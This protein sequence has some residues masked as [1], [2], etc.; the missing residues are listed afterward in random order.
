MEYGSDTRIGSHVRLILMDCFETLVQLTD[1]GYVARTG[2]ERFIQHFS[3]KRQIPIVVISDA[4]EAAIV[5]A[6]RQAG[7][8]T[9]ISGIYDA[10]ASEHLAEGRV[11]KRL[12]VPLSDMKSTAAATVF[13][14]DSPLDADAARYHQVPFIRVPRSEDRT[15]S[16]IRLIDG[17]SRYRSG[18]FI[19]HLEQAYRLP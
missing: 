1:Q 18:E 15:F 9:R 19:V 11:R 14:G 10:R 2:I 7:L 16:F 6:L 8:L 13:I 5:N 17:P 12:D 4:P 3:G